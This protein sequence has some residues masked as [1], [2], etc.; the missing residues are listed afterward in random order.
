[1]SYAEGTSVS[2]EVS[3]VEVERI[4]RRYGATNTGVVSDD[5][6]GCVVLGFTVEGASYRITVPMPTVGG[7]RVAVAK[8]DRKPNGWGPDK[9]GRYSQA[10]RE[11]ILRK[12]VEQTSRERWRAV[13]LLLKAKIELVR[14]GVSTIDREFL[15]NMV[16]PSGRTV[17]ETIPDIIRR[18]LTDETRA[19]P[20]SEER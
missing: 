2:V 12:R 14:L 8:L 19:L 15:A 16:L 3:R 18:G 10:A 4:L 6:S 13:V 9:R 11:S 20:A 17:S 5:D 1:M 7:E